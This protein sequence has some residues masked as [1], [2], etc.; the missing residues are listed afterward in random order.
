MPKLSVDDLKKIKERVQSTITLRN[1]N[2]RVKITVHMG[3]C[4]ITAGARNVMNTISDEIKNRNIKDIFL[5]S[6]GCAGLCSH[7]P[8]ATVEIK[9]TS[10]VKYID[11]DTEKALKIFDEHVLNGKIVQEYAIARGSETAY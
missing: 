5:T 1:E 3:T 2:H 7:E 10:P 9:G 6:S 4:G 11:L 8:M